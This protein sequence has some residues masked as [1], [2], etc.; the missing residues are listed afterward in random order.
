VQVIY[1]HL[2]IKK[3]TQYFG[4]VTKNKKSL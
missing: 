1:I 2:K 3:K 4:T